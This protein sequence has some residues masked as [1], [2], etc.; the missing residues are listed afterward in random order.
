[1]EDDDKRGS[2]AV[3][4]IKQHYAHIDILLFLR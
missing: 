1:M 2:K 4:A 3:Y